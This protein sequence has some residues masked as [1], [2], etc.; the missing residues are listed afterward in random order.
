MNKFIV[1]KIIKKDKSIIYKYSV[2]GKWKKYFDLKKVFQI[3]YD[4]DIE[5]IPE[6]ICVI[7]LITNILPIVWI[8]NATLEINEI[9]KDFFYSIPEFKKG[10]INMYPQINF[11][12]DIKIKKV[13]ENEYE[14]TNNVGQFFSGGVDAFSTLVTHI[15]EKPLLINLQGSDIDL[16]NNV[17]IDNIKKDIEDTAEKLNLNTTFV[18]STFKNIIRQKKA[19]LYTE[20]IVNDGYWH[21]F[22]H[23]LAIIGHG[24]PIAYYFKLKKIYIAATFTEK[25]HVPCAS[26]PSIDN[27]VR[28]SK[29]SIFHDGYNL[30]RQEKIK[31]IIHYASNTSQ[32]LKL[33]VCLDENSANNC[34][35]CEKCYRTIYEIIVNDYDPH[36]LGFFYDDTLF[37]RVKKDFNNKIVLGHLIHWTR[38]QKTFLSKKEKYEND[39]RFNWI[40]NYNFSTKMNFR[41]FICKIYYAI[42]KRIK[43]IL[44]H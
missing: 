7:P 26:D 23:G 17:V 25:I 18:K 19:T 24:A 14:I 40:L 29:T 12:G 43:K 13:I 20:K 2:I 42:I 38:I 33:R 6:S 16:N 22:Q 32:D 8:F 21:A 37:K 9:D 35:H 27:Y 28:L 1:E 15:D 11:K 30:D 44:I 41:K 4:F 36:K 31:N 5:K 34:C 3:N 10:F 39:D